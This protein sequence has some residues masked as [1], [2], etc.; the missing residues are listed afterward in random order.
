LVQQ[1]RVPRDEDDPPLDN[2][3]HPRFRFVF[4]EKFMEDGAVSPAVVCK[5]F[6]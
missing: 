3:L 2:D 4:N 6:F 5:Q 1:C